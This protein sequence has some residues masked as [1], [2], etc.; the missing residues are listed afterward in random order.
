[1][2]HSTEPAAHYDRVTQAWTHL[3]GEDFHVGYFKESAYA[4]SEAAAALTH[5]MADLACFEP[6]MQILDVGCGTGN[7]AA[8]IASQFNCQV[9]GISTSKSCVETA[10]A[11]AQASGLAGRLSFRIAD[12]LD[13]GFEAASFDRIW[14]MESSHLIP[15]KDRLLAECVRMLRSAGKVVLCDYFS[16]TDLDFRQALELRRDILVLQEVFGRATMRDVGFYLDTFHRLGV[17]TEVYD[18]SGSVV[19]TFDFWRNN[20]QRH[21]DIVEPILGAEEVEKFVRGCEVM[22]R[23]FRQGLWGYGIIVATKPNA[24]ALPLP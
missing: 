8:Y 24:S 7:P 12:A 18:I 17:S 15:Q 16:R 21:R 2:K 19:P 3:I 1:M 4:L 5:Y 9:I 23:F 11:R 6:G 14:V 13:S 22:T 10:T 20:A